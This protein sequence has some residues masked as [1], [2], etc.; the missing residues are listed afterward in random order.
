MD[1]CHTPE[2]QDNTSVVKVKQEVMSGGRTRTIHLLAGYQRE[3]ASKG[4]SVVGSPD[5][6]H[7]LKVL[8][9]SCSAAAPA[10][11]PARPSSPAV[12]SEIQIKQ[13]ETSN[14]MAQK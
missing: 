2:S 9:L 13:R 1:L 10:R 7:L 11:P 12:F 4:G 14:G 8:Q 3:P 5:R 6:Q